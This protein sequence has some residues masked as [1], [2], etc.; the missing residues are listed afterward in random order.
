MARTKRKPPKN[1]PAQGGASDQL[2][3]SIR[4]GYT[5]HLNLPATTDIAVFNAIFKSLKEHDSA[6][7][8]TKEIATFLPYI[9]DQAQKE[10]A[11][12]TKGD[13]L[14]L[15]CRIASTGDSNFIEDYV[16]LLE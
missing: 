9:M 6:E 13:Y 16:K 2:G 12:V 3:N 8:R 5:I 14:S 4:L 11:E 7:N 15:I 1:A 10:L